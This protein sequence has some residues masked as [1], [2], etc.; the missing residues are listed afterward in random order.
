MVDRTQIPGDASNVLD[1]FYL[2]L[3]RLAETMT[4]QA[5]LFEARRRTAF[6]CDYLRQL[7]REIGVRHEFQK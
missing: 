6:M 2:K 5:G 1:T 3:I 4:T 7:Y